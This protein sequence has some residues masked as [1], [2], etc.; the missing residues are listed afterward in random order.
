MKQRIILI[1]TLLALTVTFDAGLAFDNKQGSENKNDGTPQNSGN[2]I[3]CSAE[4]P[5]D[6]TGKAAEKAGNKTKKALGIAADKTSQALERAGKRIRD[7][8]DDKSKASR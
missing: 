2:R 7:W 5:L 8:F 6:K 1:L 4:T 3:S